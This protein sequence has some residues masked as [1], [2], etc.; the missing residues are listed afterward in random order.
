MSFWRSWAASL[1]GVSGA[2]VAVPVGLVLTVVV[3]AAVSGGGGFGGLAQLTS[4]PEIPGVAGGTS[5]TAAPLDG[6][7]PALPR[8]D[9]RRTTRHGRAAPA[10]SPSKT[11]TDSPGTTTPTTAPTETVTTTPTRPNGPPRRPGRLPTL[12]TPATPAPA[13]SSQ[14]TPATTPD[15][16]REAV[17]TLQGVVAPLPVLGDPVAD[18]VGTVADLIL[19]PTGGK[20]PGTTGSGAAA[21][22][23]GP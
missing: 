4:G 23:A 8:S 3:A 18:A 13:T 1:V 10:S 11:A 6:G 22:P 9:R 12:T 5:T 19:P 21:L 15:P 2:A 20:A 14:T 17:K 16:L 7:L